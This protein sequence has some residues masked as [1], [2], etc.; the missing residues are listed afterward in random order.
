M[1]YSRGASSTTISLKPNANHQRTLAAIVT[2][3]DALYRA[4]LEERLATWAGRR[5]LSV[6]DQLEELSTILAAYPECRWIPTSALCSALSRA[7]R[8]FRG[9]Q[10]RTVGI[11]ELIAQSRL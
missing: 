1:T 5:A 11:R 2:R 6:A 10:Q 8:R 3:C 7:D 4:A 9:F